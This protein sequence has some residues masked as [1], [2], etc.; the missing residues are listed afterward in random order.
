L[1]TTAAACVAFRFFN[2]L[3]TMSPV[4][5]GTV[6]LLTTT[7]GPSMAS[8]IEVAAAST[9]ERSASPPSPSGVLTAMIA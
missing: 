9:Y 1:E 5:G 4:R 8:A 6:D 2:T 3:A 7:S